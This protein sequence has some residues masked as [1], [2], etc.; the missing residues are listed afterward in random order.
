M[1]MY[2]LTLVAAMTLGLVCFAHSDLKGEGD[3]AIERGALMQGCRISIGT[4]R[5]AF[6]ISQPVC[7]RLL[8]ENRG[9]HPVRVLVASPLEAYQLDVRT[10][11]GNAAALTPSGARNAESI[12]T[13]LQVV[14]PGE[15][16]SD[17]IPDLSRLFEMTLL[18]EY[19]ITVR[20]NVLV[21]DDGHTWTEIESNTV[22]VRIHGDDVFEK[23][24]IIPSHPEND[25]LPAKDDDSNIQL[26]EHGRIIAF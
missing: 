25:G 12:S 16:I 1:N 17:S 10:P 19:T 21:A 13:H 9:E 20:C 14:A 26:D 11:T 22:K 23:G 15:S 24:P 7:V 6:H 3:V 8:L 18:G 5:E 2:R 4:D